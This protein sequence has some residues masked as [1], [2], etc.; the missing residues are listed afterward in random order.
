M[1]PSVRP[2]RP[3]DIE[4][5]FEI[6]KRW[7][8]TPGWSREQFQREL[9]FERSYFVVLELGGLVRGYAGLWILPPEAQ[10]TT[11]AVAPEAAGQGLGRLLLGHLIELCRGRGLKKISLEA[12]A[13]NERALRLYR[14]FGFRVVGRRAKFYNDGSDAILMDLA[15]P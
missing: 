5:L 12:S 6:E 8:T 11:L 3:Q 9:D 2:A 1:K 13:K 10:V 7:P 15:L 14:G 4:A